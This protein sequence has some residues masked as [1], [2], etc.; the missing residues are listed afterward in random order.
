MRTPSSTAAL[1]D[2]LQGRLEQMRWEL[3]PAFGRVVRF[4]QPDLAV[5]IAELQTMADRLCL[6]VYEG[7]RYETLHEG[8]HLHVRRTALV[9][10]L[11][12]DR[13]VANRAEA[14][15]GGPGL[16][17]VVVLKDLVLGLQTGPTQPDGTS[18]RPV[19]GRLLPGVYV[20]P[21]SA[22][23]LTPE[24]HPDAWVGRGAWLVRLE[25]VG[26]QLD[27]DLGQQPMV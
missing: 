20:R 10:L 1:L 9:G 14:V 18:P 2:A 24:G 16:P 7:D 11:M 12:A 8:R 17:G 3:E 27:F 21:V 15:F 4:D 26:G 13:Q 22:T 23:P 25:L 6:M 5:A 19:V